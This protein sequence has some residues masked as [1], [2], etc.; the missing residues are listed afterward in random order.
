MD[1][2]LLEKAE[3]ILTIT[4]N[5]PEKRNSLNTD[6]L[7]RLKDV[8][9]NISLGDEIRVIILRGAGVKAFCSG[10]DIS[11]SKTEGSQNLLQETIQSVADC[12]CP[13]IAMIYGYAVGAGCDLATACDF[14][15]IADSGY[16]GIN[17]V[18]LGSVY[19]PSSIRRF[20]N[21]IGSAY[22]KELFITGKFFTAQRAKEMGLVNYVVTADELPVITYQIANEIAENAPLAVAWTKYII[23]MYTNSRPK[24]EEEEE[25]E[26][27]AIMEHSW[28][29]D[30]A[31]EGIMAFSERRK[32]QFK[33]R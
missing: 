10:A 9:S 23:N 17:P 18:K 16:I 6:V 7:C 14:R 2:L 32:P 26:I 8:F 20:I 4:I 5:R 31:K 24:L 13:V 15:I 1:V 25:D 29:T 30:D 27:Q 19:Y 33:G 12:S 28:Q 22:T 11:A 21:I 3:H